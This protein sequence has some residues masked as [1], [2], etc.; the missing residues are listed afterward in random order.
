M[1]L[2]TIGVHVRVYAFI[3]PTYF[4]FYTSLIGQTL[5]EKGRQHTHDVY[6][7]TYAHLF[8]Q[9]MCCCCLLLLSSTV[10]L[11]N[12]LAVFELST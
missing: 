11:C 4:A 2:K 7:S 9:L 12:S 1:E 8:L 5:W 10:G 3:L 6:V